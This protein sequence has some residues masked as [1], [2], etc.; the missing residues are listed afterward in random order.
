MAV[1]Y[2]D[3]TNSESSEKT[4]TYFPA[5]SVLYIHVTGYL[6]DTAIRITEL[7]HNSF[8]THQE[9]LLQNLFI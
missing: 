6:H 1:E 4:G 3:E 8:G 2:V 9:S 5:P 7:F